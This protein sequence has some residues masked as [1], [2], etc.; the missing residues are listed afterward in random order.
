MMEFARQRPPERAPLDLARAVEAGLRLASFDKAFKRLEVET[1]FEPGAPQVSADQDQLQQVFLNLLLNARDAMPGGGRLR[2]RTSYDGAA[3]E[4]VA[5]VSDEGEGI[6]ADALPHVF[7]P[8]FTTKRAGAGLGLAVCYG[9]VTAHGGRVE[10]ESEE[11]RGTTVRVAL[12]AAAEEPA[13]SGARAPR[14]AATLER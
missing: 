6:A 3:R 5:E 8:F 7:D 10:V 1:D 9:I 12:P 4:V 2:L 14:A 11:G 13:D